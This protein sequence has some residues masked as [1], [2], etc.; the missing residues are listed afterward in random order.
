[1][2]S[3]VCAEHHQILNKCWTPG[4]KKVRVLL[5]LSV[6]MIQ[7]MSKMLSLTW[8]LEYARC[9]E[10]EHNKIMNIDDLDR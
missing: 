4:A 10:P 5:L 2:W 1:M 7:K 3:Q 8:E 6:N 9:C